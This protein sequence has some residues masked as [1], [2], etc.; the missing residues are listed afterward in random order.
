MHL[1]N[2][3]S[4]FHLLKF[5][6]FNGLDNIQRTAQNGSL[7]IDSEFFVYWEEMV[8]VKKPYKQSPKNS[9]E[10]HTVQ[11]QF[12]TQNQLEC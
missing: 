3:T 11:N 7:S 5:N 8:S 10:K 12:P 4:P 9:P 2:K 1:K 6:E